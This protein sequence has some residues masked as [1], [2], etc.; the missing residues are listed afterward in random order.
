M[1]ILLFKGQFTKSVK[2]IKLTKSKTLVGVE[3][4]SSIFLVEFAIDIQCITCKAYI[5]SIAY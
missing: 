2:P 5:V 3:C 1:S 4:S